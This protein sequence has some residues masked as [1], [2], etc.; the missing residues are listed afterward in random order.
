M[1]KDLVVTG[2][3]FLSNLTGNFI[4]NRVPFWAL[5][6]MANLISRL[7]QVC[8]WLG[9][10]REGVVTKLATPTHMP[11]A[12]VS[13]QDYK[14][15][16][17]REE[18]YLW[19]VGTPMRYCAMQYWVLPEQVGSFQFTYALSRWFMVLYTLVQCYMVLGW[20]EGLFWMLAEGILIPYSFIPA[21]VKKPP[22]PDGKG[23]MSSHPKIYS[24]GVRKTLKRGFWHKKMMFITKVKALHALGMDWID[25]LAKDDDV[26]S[27]PE[28][29]N[30]GSIHIRPSW[31]SDEDFMQFQGYRKD[32]CQP[33]TEPEELAWACP[34]FFANINSAVAATTYG[35]A[36]V[37]VMFDTGCTTAVTPF[38]EDFVSLDESQQ[39]GQLKGIA[40]GLEIKG[41]GII[42]Y[43]IVADDGTKI[44]LRTKAYYVPDI[45]MRLV[46][47]QQLR[48]VDGHPVKFSVYTA[49]EKAKAYAELA[50][51]PKTENWK[52]SRP[53]A[54]KQIHLHPRN[55]LPYLLVKT[56]TMQEKV[57]EALQG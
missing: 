52:W 10:E 15:S 22:D 31:L 3:V 38:K 17:R 20:K 41:E 26:L 51:M 46:S 8:L 36:S 9:L 50:V 5:P 28:W 54:T 13:E 16:R 1:V 56:S 47:P 39:Q 25:E 12:M 19:S 21:R 18:P 53:M 11:H 55:N 57:K 27:P 34:S 7:A 40:N 23:G 45:K 42:E 29:D 24:K 6:Y 14:A 4:L 35:A 32:I 33:C 43:N 44:A 30:R 48:T 2:L 37:L 49:Y